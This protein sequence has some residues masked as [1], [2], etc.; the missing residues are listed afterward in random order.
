MGVWGV[1]FMVQ[2]VGFRVQGSGFRVQG[3][4]FRVQGSGFRVQGAGFRVQGSGFRVQG[5]TPP[6][7]GPSRRA[8]HPC[9]SGSKG[10]GLRLQGLHSVDYDGFV[11]SNSGR[12]R[13]QIV[14]DGHI[15]PSRTTRHPCAS[16]GGL[17]LINVQW[18]RGG[19]VFEAH[20][21]LYHSD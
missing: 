4:G 9:A 17:V 10:N 2:G 6:I 3:S 7:D 13:D 15:R 16:G 21:L 18:F 19:L 12:L 20:R 11:A 5:G 14:R 8:R 1:G